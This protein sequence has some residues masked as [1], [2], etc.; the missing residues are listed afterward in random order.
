MRKYLS[1]INNGIRGIWRWLKVGKLFVT[2]F[3]VILIASLLTVDN[4]LHIWVILI[5]GAVLTIAEMLNYAI[6]QLCDLIVG[7]GYNDQVRL[8]KDV[9][10]G[11]VLAAGAILGIA[12]LWIIFA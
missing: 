10:A 5:L 6:E 3:L 4:W 1:R 12:G 8:I 2:F 7:K 11:A 9:C